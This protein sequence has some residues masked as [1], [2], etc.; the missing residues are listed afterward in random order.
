MH[1]ADAPSVALDDARAGPRRLAKRVQR[2]DA[3]DRDLQDLGGTIRRAPDRNSGAVADLA[4]ERADRVIGR[5]IDA[6]DLIA[7]LQAGARC[8]TALEHRIDEIA[9]IDAH[10]EDTDAGERYAGA[11]EAVVELLLRH[12]GAAEHRHQDV[13][14]DIVGR[15]QAGVRALELAKQRVDTASSHLEVGSLDHARAHLCGTLLPADGGEPILVPERLRR[16][17]D[18]GIEQRAE[19]LRSGRGLGFGF[20]TSRWA[21]WRLL[22]KRRGGY[23]DRKSENS[24][25]GKDVSAGA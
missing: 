12:G 15:K 18:D 25:A 5:A 8:R 21:A 3:H 22:R 4:A 10:R 6:D 14:V 24:E 17:R 20:G 9:A 7:D 23:R 19:V 16:G 11:P 2:G 1:V 13:V